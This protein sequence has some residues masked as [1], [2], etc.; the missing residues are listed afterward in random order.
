MSSNKASKNVVLVDM[1]GVIV[2]YDAEFAK[3]WAIMRP[4]RDDYD[5]IRSRTDFDIENNFPE[6]DYSDVCKVIAE[7]GF[8]QKLLPFKGAIEALNEMDKTGFHVL[9]CSSPSRFQFEESA[10]G[11]YEWIRQWLGEDWMERLILTRDKTVVDAPVLI[12]DKPKI[13]GACK[14]PTWTQV[15]FTQPYNS[16]I[17]DKP[18]MSDWSEWRCV[19]KPFYPHLIF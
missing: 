15:L 10:S 7:G 14:D 3:R 8:F 5:L 9:L 16:R 17:Q 6:E 1:D 11:K 18:R 19:L 2:D 13:S 4:D 12:D